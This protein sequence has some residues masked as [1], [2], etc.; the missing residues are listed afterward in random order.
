MTVRR[1]APGARTCEEQRSGR[2]V[3]GS[4]LPVEGWGLQS[5]IRAGLVALATQSS[6]SARY[7]MMSASRRSREVKQISMTLTTIAAHEKRPS[8]YL[9]RKAPN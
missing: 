5:G 4:D 3:S 8:T 9:I 2:G 1:C 6:L 7:G